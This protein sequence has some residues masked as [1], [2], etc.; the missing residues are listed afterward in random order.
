MSFELNWLV[1]IQIS[2]ELKT[3]NKLFQNF[4]V[5]KHIKTLVL[6]CLKTQRKRMQ[7]K[8]KWQRK[9]KEIWGNR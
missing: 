1:C 3:L 9:E 6:L 8:I 2:I 4:F 7:T 5:L